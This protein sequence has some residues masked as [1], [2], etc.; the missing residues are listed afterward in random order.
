MLDERIVGSQKLVRLAE[1]GFA[2]EYQC[3]VLVC[4]FV[5]FDALCRHKAPAFITPLAPSPFP[6]VLCLLRVLSQD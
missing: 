3:W 1:A 6:Q 2:P 4:I 5:G